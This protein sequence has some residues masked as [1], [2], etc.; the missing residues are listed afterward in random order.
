MLHLFAVFHK[1]TGGAATATTFGASPSRAITFG[2][3][4][5]FYEYTYLLQL[6]VKDNEEVAAAL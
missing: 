4:I 3:Y 1:Y 5:L 6:A 2:K